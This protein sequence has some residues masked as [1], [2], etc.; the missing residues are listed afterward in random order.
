M[1]AV[2]VGAD[3]VCATLNI[4]C[5][6]AGNTIGWIFA[7]VIGCIGIHSVCHREGANIGFIVACK[8]ENSIGSL[9]LNDAG[10]AE[11]TGTGVTVAVGADEAIGE[12]AGLIVSSGALET[13]VVAAGLAVPSGALE[14]SVVA[15]SYL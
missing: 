2:S 8:G 5:T 6:L 10:A 11:G 9:C 15:G 12:T 4:Q 3:L 14:A 7:A 13:S 1:Q